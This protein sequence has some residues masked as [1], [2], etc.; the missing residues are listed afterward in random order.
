MKNIYKIIYTIIIIG[1]IIFFIHG[2][3][4]IPIK[5]NYNINNVDEKTN[6][7]SITYSSII[8]FKK[9]DTIVSCPTYYY[10][11]ILDNSYV[12]TSNGIEYNTVIKIKGKIY[13][14]HG[15]DVY[16]KVI[17]YKDGDSIKLLE[18]YWPY[19]RIESLI[20]NK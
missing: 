2:C 14:Y 18:V 9:V 11:K 5:G 3:F 8:P 10:A 6:T 15:K 4:F 1:L 20:D 16:D 13:T 19:Y 17:A 7:M 12:N